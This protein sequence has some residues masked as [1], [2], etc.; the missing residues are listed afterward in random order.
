MSGRRGARRGLWCL[1]AGEA[2]SITGTTMTTVAIPWF[3]LATT[4][5]AE[6]AG[7]AAFASLLPL[8]ISAFFGGAIV[9]RVGHRR[10]SV[11][12]DLAGGLLAAT[13]PVLF[14]TV[15]LGFAPLLALLFG[16]W[17]LAAPGETARRA[18]VPALAVAGGVRMERA[19][20]GFDAVSRGAR[21]AGAPLAGV[22]IA[23]F[24]GTRLGPVAVLYADAAT[25][26][27]SA[28][29]IGVGV[30][31]PPGHVAA[32][33]DAGPVGGGYLAR[34][35]EGLAFLWREPVLRAI[36]LMVLATNTLD[37]AWNQVLLPLYAR[38]SLGDPRALGLLMGL[39]G[40]GAMVGALVYGAVGARLPRWRTYAVC[41]LAAGVPRGFV[42][43]AGAAFPLLVGTQAVCG[44]LAGALNP[45]I[46]VV[47]FERIPAR[48]RAR[49]MGAGDAGA[50]AGMPV[51]GLLAGALAGAAGL[52]ASLLVFGLLYLTVCLAPFV[53]KVWRQLDGT[54]PAAP[55]RPAPESA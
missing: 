13:V 8:V 51:G 54:P 26:A 4:G 1:L 14:G 7:L 34:L 45:L 37:A 20:A 2:V 19:T 46:G 3:V 25:F 15:G 17:L 36:T 27:V 5:S 48:L 55:P 35:K 30:P 29:L 50:F 42:F 43:A 11:L 52:T 39:P 6:R 44:L 12:C 22:L 28:A 47:E 23:V 31:R 10:S 9:D 41:F 32:G 21:M 40:A 24:G 53:G 18:L 33:Q 16:R 38:D 49:V